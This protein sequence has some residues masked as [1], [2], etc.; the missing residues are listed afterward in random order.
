MRGVVLEMS[1]GQGD[2][3]PL[4]LQGQHSHRTLQSRWETT[5]MNTQK[6]PKIRT[7]GVA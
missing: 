4:R 5:Q 7:V 2:E 6:Q 1:W 3:L